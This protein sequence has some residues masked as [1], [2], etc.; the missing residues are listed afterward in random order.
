M[1]CL[2]EQSQ[3][4]LKAL[5]GWEKLIV[6]IQKDVDTLRDFFK[7]NECPLFEAIYDLQ[8]A[9]TRQM[10]KEIGDPDEWLLW[11]WLENGMGKRGFEVAQGKDGRSIRNLEDLA[12]W[13]ASL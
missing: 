8:I 10:A 11:Y 5:E 7:A 9:Y 2:N 3:S 6:A 13:I 4:I 12:N 1:T